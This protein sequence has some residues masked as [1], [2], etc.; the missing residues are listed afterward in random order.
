MT[1]DHKFKD[2]IMY[3][4]DDVKIRKFE[5]TDIEKKIE[6]INNPE[7]NE[8]L[9]YDLPLEY[10]KTCKW[11]ENIKDSKNRYD[12]VIE[13]KGIPVGIVG[14]LNIDRKNEKC[15]EYITIGDTSLK[16]KGIATKALELICSYAFNDLKLNKVTAYVEYGNPSLYL[17]TKVGFHIE[18]FLKNDLIVDDEYRDR[19]I[20]GLFKRDLSKNRK[21]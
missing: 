19:F 12:A 2:N 7:N 16:R 15:E 4:F 8:Y 11:F 18:G 5:F 9:H 10:E 17:H 3:K 14:L 21:E 20:L 1:I 13:Y 6:W